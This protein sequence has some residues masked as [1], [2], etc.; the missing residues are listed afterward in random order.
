MNTAR[1]RRTR[2]LKVVLVALAAL[3]AAWLVALVG[4]E[5]RQAEA[6][7]A[8]HYTITDLEAIPDN[9][10]SEATAINTSGQIVGR[11]FQQRSE[12]LT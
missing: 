11:L 5:P 8:P 12:L 10:D 6:V 3:L 9:T 1:L 2:F 4:T 7:D